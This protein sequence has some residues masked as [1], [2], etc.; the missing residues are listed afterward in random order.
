MVGAETIWV[1]ALDASP[2]TERKITGKHGI[3]LATVRAALVGRADYRARW[4]DHP[5]HGFRVVVVARDGAGRTFIAWLQP[6]VD[7]ES[8]TLRTARYV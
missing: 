3:D 2:A 8:W 1:V 4:E 6:T 7:R 5:D